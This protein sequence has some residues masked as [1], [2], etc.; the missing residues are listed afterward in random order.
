[1]LVEGQQLSPVDALRDLAGTVPGREGKVCM[2][3]RGGGRPRQPSRVYRVHAINEQRRTHTH[4]RCCRS[5]RSL[6]SLH[7]L[8]VRRGKRVKKKKKKMR[9]ARASSVLA[10]RLV[11]SA[12]VLSPLPLFF[13]LSLSFVVFLSTMRIILFLLL[14]RPGGNVVLPAAVPRLEQTRIRLAHEVDEASRGHHHALVG[15][16]AVRGQVLPRVG[17]TGGSV[18]GPVRYLGGLAG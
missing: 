2:Y 1:M 5:T 11:L 6:P 7:L 8:Q 16:L 4:T 15:V 10:P 17:R 3:A 18:D 12:R 13:V 14:G 9:C